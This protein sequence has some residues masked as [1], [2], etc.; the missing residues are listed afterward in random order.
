M[1]RED[2]SLRK[3]L[4]A[5]EKEVRRGAQRIEDAYTPM[6]LGGYRPRDKSSVI[7]RKMIVGTLGLA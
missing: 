3:C 4:A 5:A 1:T 7:V 2:G 6:K